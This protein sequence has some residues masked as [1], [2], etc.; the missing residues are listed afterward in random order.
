MLFITVTMQQRIKIKLQLKEPCLC[1]CPVARHTSQG[2]LPSQV[3]I[4][5]A[6]FFDQYRFE[7]GFFLYEAVNRMTYVELFKPPNVVFANYN[8]PLKW[9]VFWIFDRW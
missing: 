7:I 6:A 2:Y 5:T 4:F 3:G 1:C 8:S 9:V